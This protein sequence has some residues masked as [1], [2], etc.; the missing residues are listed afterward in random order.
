[1]FAISLL[2]GG[3]VNHFAAFI[4]INLFKKQATRAAAPKKTHFARAAADVS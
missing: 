1:M 4:S 2:A 3:A